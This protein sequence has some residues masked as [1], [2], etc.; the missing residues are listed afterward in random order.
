MYKGPIIKRGRKII[1]NNLD[2]KT[3]EAAD[4]RVGDTRKRKANIKKAKKPK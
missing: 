2:F 3:I 4:L 1:V